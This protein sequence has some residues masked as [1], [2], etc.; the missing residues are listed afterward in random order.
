MVNGTPITLEGDEG[1]QIRQC[2]LNGTVPN[3]DLINHLLMTA[4][5]LLK[6]VKKFIE[7][8]VTMHTPYER[9][10]SD[11]E[12]LSLK[13]TVSHIDTTCQSTVTKDKNKSVISRDVAVSKEVSASES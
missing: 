4:G 3:Q 6:P 10:S 9:L 11:P 2:L 13:V 12:N 8:E 1:E 7:A 5:L